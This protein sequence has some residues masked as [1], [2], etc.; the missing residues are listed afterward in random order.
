MTT[1]NAINTDGHE[2]CS[3]RRKH[4]DYGQTK[5]LPISYEW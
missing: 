3:F 1:N 2:Q 4:Y 5:L